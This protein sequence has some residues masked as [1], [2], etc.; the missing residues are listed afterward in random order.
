MNAMTL[1]TVMIS[2]SFAALICAVPMQWRDDTALLPYACAVQPAASTD[3]KSFQLSESMSAW[4]DASMM[5][6]ETPTVVQ[7]AP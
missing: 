1:G 5:L 6:G 3:F 2:A 4:N 7:L